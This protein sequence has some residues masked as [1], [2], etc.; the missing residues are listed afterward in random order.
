MLAPD[1]LADCGGEGQQGRI[2]VDCRADPDR[3]RTV[4]LPIRDSGPGISEEALEHLF[5]PFYT[6]R[7][8]GTGLGLAI[9]RRIVEAHDGTTISSASLEGHP[10]LLF[11]YPKAETPG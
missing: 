7:D 10:Y 8:G 3:R 1:V 9:T 5:E 2:A 6:S 11:F 4:R